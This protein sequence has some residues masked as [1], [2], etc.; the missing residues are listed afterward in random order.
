M[1]RAQPRMRRS[2]AALS[3]TTNPSPTVCRNRI[4]GYAQSELDSRTQTANAV[5]STHVRNCIRL[6]AAYTNLL[7][8]AHGRD[9]PCH[10]E[11][12]N[13]SAS[14]GGGVQVGHVL[15]M[16]GRARLVD[17]RARV[18]NRVG[19]PGLRSAR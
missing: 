6:Q 5:P 12:R 10:D 1:R 11:A 16:T 4:V 8:A 7:A 14:G 3:P 15:Q 13:P 17:L 18:E 19:V 2:I 9:G